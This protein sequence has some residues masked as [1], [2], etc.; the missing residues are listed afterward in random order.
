MP[1]VDLIDFEYG[2][3]SELDDWRTP[4][5]LDSLSGQSLETVGRVV[6]SRAEPAERK[7]PRQQPVE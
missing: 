1:A 6:R 4:T 5:T 3:A 7:R 2:S